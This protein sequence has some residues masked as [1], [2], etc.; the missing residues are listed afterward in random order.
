VHI[1]EGILSFRESALMS[2]AAVGAMAVGS[3]RLKA[4]YRRKP[5]VRPLVGLLGA[6]VFAV[7]LMPIPVPIVGT[8]SHPV[9]TPLAA[10]L[11]GPWIASLLGGLV[12]LLQAALFAHGGFSTYGANMLAMAVAGSFVGYGTFRLCRGL[13]LSA[14]AAAAAAG[15]AG[16]VAT[17]VV[18]AGIL[19]GFSAMTDPQGR[20]FGK[21]FGALLLAYAPVQ[22]PLA[23][24]EG[25]FT[26]VAVTRLMRMR[27]DLLGRLGRAGLPPRPR[28][29]GT[30]LILLLA[31][32]ALGA[33]HPVQ[34]VSAVPGGE[35]ARLAAAPPAEGNSGP[36][37]KGMDEA[38]NE[39]LARSAGRM[40]R[41]PYINTDQGDLLL[42][43]FLVGGLASGF[44]GGYCYR[45]LVTGRRASHEVGAPGPTD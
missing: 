1:A 9:G 4:L 10:I 30:L 15:I 16:D 28:P 25:A 44:A 8:C 23:I 35:A 29:P 43:F 32:L 12:L 24:V 19:A 42:F 22:G 34:A 2:V 6:A 40:S 5:E 45:T 7:S 3:S 17:Y 38:V 27:G 13:G 39:R 20:T 26:A 11:L 36:S 21:L 14:A 18:T 31:S 41:E 37:W 33:A